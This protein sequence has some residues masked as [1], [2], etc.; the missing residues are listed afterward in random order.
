MSAP[1]STSPP[2]HVVVAV[3]LVHSGRVLL[4]HRTASRQWYPDV[5]DFPGGHLENGETPTQ[6]LVR[7]LREEL[8]IVVAEPTY[9]E[10][11]RLTTSGFD[12]R[13]WLIDQ[14]SGEP[15][16]VSFDEHDELAWFSSDELRGLKLAEESYLSLLTEVLAGPRHD[17]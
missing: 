5:W 4:C 16:N 13:V 11:A 9:P 12:M 3:L 15:M 6:A 10:L 1:D 7:E 14:W 8:N 2:A 17:Q